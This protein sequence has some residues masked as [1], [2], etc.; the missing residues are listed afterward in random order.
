MY[1]HALP[2]LN[3]LIW[4]KYPIY[5]L[6]QI[7]ILL[8]FI[9]YLCVLDTALGTKGKVLR[10]CG[11]EEKYSHC[12]PVFSILVVRWTIKN[13]KKKKRKLR[14]IKY[15]KEN[16][17]RVIGGRWVSVCNAGNLGSIPGLERF[18]WRRVWQPTPVFLSGESHG[19]RSLAGY[20]PWGHKE[21]DMTK[22]LRTRVSL[23][24]VVQTGHTEQLGDIFS[25]LQVWKGRKA[26]F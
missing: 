21:L 19:Q 25:R 11:K 4:T 20:S 7:F 9:E 5:L 13:R 6:T 18:P 8:I 16:Q 24:W 17:K 22:Q 3:I 14:N 2:P 1:F 23:V 15:G 12:A 26:A 10:K